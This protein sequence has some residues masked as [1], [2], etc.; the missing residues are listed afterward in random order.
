MSQTDHAFHVK[1]IFCDLDGCVFKH[2]GDIT[3]VFANPYK[4]LPG[5][6]N[7]FR[8]WA[9]KGYKVVITTGRP[10]SMRDFTEQQM[11]EAGLYYH[12]LIMDLPRGQR[13]IINDIKPGNKGKT[14]ACVNIERNKGMENVDI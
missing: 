4:I 2:H 14:A 5:V 12:N 7:V 13:V 3:E 10:E 9:H 6:M 1:T 8:Q 11:R